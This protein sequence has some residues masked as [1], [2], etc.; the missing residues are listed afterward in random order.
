[1]KKTGT[2]SSNLT[3]RDFLKGLGMGVVTLSIPA[4]KTFAASAKKPNILLIMSDDMGFSDIGCY[5]SDIS[6]SNLDSLASNG[7]RFTQFYNCARCCPTRASLMSGLYPHQAGIGHMTEDSGLPSYRGDL[8]NNCVTIPEALRPAGYR[9]YMCGKWHVTRFTGKDGPKHNW[10]LQRGYEKFYGTIEGCGSYYD[11]A[12]LCR[13]NTYITPFNDP[14][15]KPE[16]FYYTN[17]ISDNAVKYLREHEQE[18][19]DK[20][21]FM[22]VAYTA[23]HWPMHAIEKDIEKYRGKFDKGYG[24]CREQRFAKLKQSGLINKNW[25]MSEQAGDWERVNN[26]EWE[27]RCMEVYA[28]MIDCMDQG[29]GRIIGELKKQN[30]FDN[31]LIFFLQD[32]GGCAETMGRNIGSSWV[33]AITNHDLM[34]QDELQ[35][36]IYPP[37]KTRDGQAVLGGTSVMPGPDG[38]YI[39][40]GRNWANVSNTPF[41]EYK[42]WVHEGGIST[43]LICHWPG[44]I[45]NP[46]S[47]F[48]GQGH[49]IDIMATCIDVAGAEYPKTHNEQEI[50]PIEGISLTPAFENRPLADRTI[51]WEH[52]GNLAV[53]Q[54]KWKLVLKYPGTWELYDMDKDRTEM[55]NLATEQSEKV[56]E[57]AALY[58]A[59]AK[60]CGVQPWPLRRQ[61]SR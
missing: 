58:D 54:G 30:E 20:P 40:Y 16:K 48:S 12:T 23:A 32:N 21:F 8:S 6:T 27:A 47:L 42:H 17:A 50:Q 29:I 10:P 36:M 33:R 24:Y 55:H 13:N 37:M 4:L 60:R 26:K 22:Y 11:P 39:A 49:L 38:T 51:Y 31:T 53:R 1:M 2:N 35:L 7:L 44:H 18:S 43:P 59:W 61:S 56:Q 57:L 9:T 52:E 25:D 14:E 41:R 15:Y 34:R 5:G 3:R 46:G 45:K 28:A 19:P